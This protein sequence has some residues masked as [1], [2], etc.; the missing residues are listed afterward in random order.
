[1]NII[2]KHPV[3]NLGYNFIDKK[4]LPKGKDEYYLRNIQNEGRAY[5][6]LTAPEIDLLLQNRNT[7]DDWSKIMV[8]KEFNAAQVKNCN[9]YGLVR[10]GNMEPVYQSFH[11]FKMPVGLY[12]STIISCDIGNN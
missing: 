10:I 7:S 5:R 6:H 4:F 12:N 2:E 11:D 3:N 8:S 9:F 1:M